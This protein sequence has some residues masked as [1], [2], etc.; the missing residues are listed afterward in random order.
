MLQHVIYPEKIDERIIDFITKTLRALF[1]LNLTLIYL[2]AFPFQ[3]ITYDMTQ[4]L[5]IKFCSCDVFQRVKSVNKIQK[6]QK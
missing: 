3:S 5:R 2:L 4:I 1:F 6:T